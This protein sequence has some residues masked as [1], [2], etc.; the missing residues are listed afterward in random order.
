LKRHEVAKA[1]IFGSFA[2]GPVRS[3]SDLDLLVEFQGRKSL[4]DLVGLKLDLEDLLGRPVDVVTY[5]SVHK[6]LRKI[7]LNQHI[8]IL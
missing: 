7:I 8:R 3:S 2:R 1:G 4:L 5:R 6:R